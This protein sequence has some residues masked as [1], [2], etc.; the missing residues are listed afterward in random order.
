MSRKDRSIN[1]MTCRSK[2]GPSKIVSKLQDGFGANAKGFS[3][4]GGNIIWR[5]DPL[6]AFHSNRVNLLVSIAHLEYRERMGI[7]TYE[8]FGSYLKM[9]SLI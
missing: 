2:K 4:R 7:E 8:L 6:W 9:S 3:L 1:K 5:G